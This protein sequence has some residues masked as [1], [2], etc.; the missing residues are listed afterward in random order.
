MKESTQL[1]TFACAAFAMLIAC[2]PENP[3][4]GSG[5]N[6]EKPS[7]QGTAGRTSAAI[8][9]GAGASA[10]SATAPG[11]NAGSAAAPSG[12]VAGKGGSNTPAAA[13]S[14][15]TGSGG[16]NA[17]AEPPDSSA[18]PAP[19]RPNIKLAPTKR[20][21]MYESLAP[22]VGEPL[23]RENKGMWNWIDIQGAKSR[24]GSPAGFYYKYSTS[25]S[26]NL[27]VYLVGGGVCPD[28]SFCNIN[29]ANKNQSLTAEGIGAGT[30]NALL[31]APDPEPQ[32][33]SLER[34]QSGIFKNDPANP[35]QD[36]NV[37]FIPYVTGDVFFG[38]RPDATIPDV[39]GTFQFVGKDNMQ[40]FMERI[41]PTFA[42]AEVAMMAGSSA[43]GIGTLLNA[44]Y[45]A[46]GFIDQGKGARIVILDD[47]GPFFEDEFLEVCIQKR[48]RDIFGLDASFPADCPDCITA[49]GG[50]LAKGILTY[51]VN[52]YPGESLGGLIDSNEDEIMKF[53]F[54]EGLENCSY[55]DN[56][57][58]GLLAYPPGLYP[59]AL[60][61]LLKLAPPS[62]MSSYIWEG[63]LHQNVFMTASGDR[64]YEKNGL[65]LTPA[66]WLTDL[67]A[68][69]GRRIGN[70][71]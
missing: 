31:Q 25:D 40:R 63:T 44:T 23:P 17:I 55:I 5:S 52:K 37:V 51:L 68:G 13:G 48:Y 2:G 47:A 66:E 67:L 53:F 36:W 1:H 6:A 14:S 11:R 8:G 54:S 35:L 50:G 64:F 21:P 60:T 61:S 7:G 20:S 22:A 49:D 30:G 4:P 59:Q 42:D 10:P 27:L 24:D 18:E 39:P 3:A 41:I 16:S 19:A 56:P 9:G 33:P 69:S 57:I 26:K 43:G 38:S 28:N 65:A 32:D 62:M 34:W 58:A 15:A 71:Q 12:S 46:D 70:I 29:P 45:F